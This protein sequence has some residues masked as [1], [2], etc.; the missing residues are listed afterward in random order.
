MKLFHPFE[1]EHAQ[2]VE[3]AIYRNEYS[4]FNP[5]LCSIGLKTN[6]LRAQQRSTAVAIAHDFLTNMGFFR[7]N[8]ENENAMQAYFEDEGTMMLSLA[9]IED[10]NQYQKIAL[11]KSVSLSMSLEKI[12]K[13]RRSVRQY[14]GD[15]I[16]LSCL[17]AVVRAGAGITIE[18]EN[19]LSNGSTIPFNFRA[20]P[21]AG[22]IYPVDISIAALNVAQLQPGIY[23]YSPRE[24]CLILLYKKNVLLKL[25]QCFSIVDE[26]ISLT[27]AGFICLLSGSA[28]KSINKYGAR[29]LGFTLHEIG[30]ISQNIHLA[31]TSLG[32]GSVDCASYFN[33]ETHQ[34]LEMDGIY[35][36]LFH[37]IVVGVNQ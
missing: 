20:A 16:S 21:S 27:R 15:V 23:R 9:D 24:D 2:I 35:Q 12:I 26:Q 13:K 14:T 7:G 25:M 36:H 18:R 30:S 8:A 22:G 34:V 28:P 33:D 6:V 11:P 29:G 31:V 17:A 4:A 10:N 3:Q 37:T 19:Q 5:W 1:K 32:L